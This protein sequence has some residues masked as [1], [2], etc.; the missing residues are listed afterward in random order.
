MVLPGSWTRCVPYLLAMLA[1]SACGGGG[2]PRATA[3]PGPSNRAPTFTSPPALSVP[4]NTSGVFFTVAASDPDG[5]AVSF[6]LT[7]GPDQGR[8][9]ISPAGAL[10]FVAPP[11]FESPGDSNRDNVYQVTVTASDGNATATQSLTVTVTDVVGTTFRVRRVVTGLD[12]PVFLAPV[13]DGSGRV[14]VAQ[15][16]GRVVI[17]TPSTGQVAATPFLDV[18]TQVSTDGERGLLGFATAP[19]YASSGTFYVY[20][21]ALDGAIEVRRYRTL[22]GDPNRAD[23]ASGDVILRIAHPRTNHNGGWIGFAADNLLYIATGDGGGAGDP[24]NNGQ[25]RNTLL[26]KIL[27][28]DPSR[29]AFPTEAD[30]DYAIPAANPFVAGGGA[31][32]VLAYGLRN[33]FRCSFDPQTGNLWIGDPGQDTVEEID[34]LGPEDAGANF[35]WPIME[36]TVPF[37]GGSTAGLTLPVAEYRNGVGP[38]EGSTVIGG[39][40]YRGGVESLQGQYLFGDF[41]QPNLWSFP[42]AAIIPGT[43][44]PSAQFTIRNIDFAPDVGVYTNIVS[45]GVDQSGQ[46]YIVDLNGDIFVIEPVPGGVPLAQSLARPQAL[47]RMPPWMGE[48]AAGRLIMRR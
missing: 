44:L 41:T 46:V 10:T 5:N 13:P 27:R 37:R 45:F 38:R 47:G 22:A 42:I 15:L 31:P 24:D 33:P 7:G 8:L 14:F 48:R 25:N 29:D 26:G 12:M 18:T 30:R 2:S 28:V 36:G 16:P 1:L 23:P 3:S 6:S 4:E 21:T 43:T 9:R 20:L 17:L 34:L 11:D 32:E 40:V 39:Y 35:G 19:D